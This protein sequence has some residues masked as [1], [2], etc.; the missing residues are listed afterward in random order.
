ME[1]HNQAAVLERQMWRGVNQASVSVFLH[2]GLWYHR[3]DKCVCSKR[4][5]S[6]CLK[7]VHPQ[8]KAEYLQF[9]RKSHAE[10]L[11]EENRRHRF[12]AEKHC[13]LV[14]SIGQIINKVYRLQQGHSLN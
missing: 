11:E 9:L 1:V 10:A 12:L 8:D 7:Y 4:A 14:Q 5:C 6:K 3:C 2:L 13:S